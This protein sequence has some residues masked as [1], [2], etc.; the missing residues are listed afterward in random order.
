MASGRLASPTEP[1]R[2][3]RKGG[4]HRLRVDFRLDPKIESEALAAVECVRGSEY[5]ARSPCPLSAV[6]TE[7]NTASRAGSLLSVS[8]KRLK[9]SPCDGRL[10]LFLKGEDDVELRVSVYALV[11]PSLIVALLPRDMRPGDYRVIVRTLSRGGE[12]L[13]GRLVVRLRIEGE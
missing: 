7:E 6:A 13:E 12:P 1:F 4:D 3:G 9:F 2:P 10:G 8:G 11:R 5:D